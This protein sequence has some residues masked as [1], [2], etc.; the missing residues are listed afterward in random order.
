[1]G[2]ETILERASAYTPSQM[3]QK[4]LRTGNVKVALTLLGPA[5]RGLV[6]H[7]GKQPSSDMP[8][9]HHVHFDW[10]YQRDQDELRRL[11]EAAKTGQWNATTDLDWSI[12]VDPYNPD[13]DL[14]P[15]ALIPLPDV[16]SYRKL[17]E[18]DKQTHRLGLA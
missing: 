9:H 11:Y 6:M 8:A 7:G 16:P 12:D 13:R 15:E 2:V 18:R 1:M 5:I 3:L 4:V 14:F 17:P 10:T